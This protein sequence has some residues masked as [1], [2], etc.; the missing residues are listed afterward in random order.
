MNVFSTKTAALRAAPD[1]AK[2]VRFTYGMVLNAEDFGQEF[3]YLSARDQWMVRDLVGYGTVSGLKVTYEQ[4]GTRPRLVV[5]PGVAV[6]PRGEMVRVGRAQCAYLNDW[7]KTDEAAARA[8]AAKASPTMS[9]IDAYVT[10]CY[11]ACETDDLPIPGEPCRDES[12]MMAPS[13]VA[14]DFKLELRLDPP[15]QPDEQAV[16]DFVTW[17]AGIPIVDG[18][19]SVT[20]SQFLEAIK[21]AATLI[22]S[23]PSSPP[24]FMYGAPPAAVQ[25]GRADACRY[26]RAAYRLWV[27]ELRARWSAS[28]WDAQAACCGATAPAESPESC[29]L[30]TRVSIPLVIGGP[31]G[32]QAWQVAAAPEP[33]IDDEERPFLVP[34]R[35]LQEWLWCGCACSSSGSGAAAEA[36]GLVVAAGHLTVTSPPQPPV[37]RYQLQA[38]RP[39]PLPPAPPAWSAGDFWVLF[40]DYQRPAPGGDFSYVVSVTPMVGP[41]VNPRL[42]VAAFDTEGIRLRLKNNTVPASPTNLEFMIE[43][44][45]YAR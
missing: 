6:T 22:G 1:P 17:L 21:Y 13:R 23:P 3:A 34:V 30:L 42:E 31:A 20:L 25:I 24:D 5:A 9:R 15:A 2:H 4:N 37:G 33:E 44:K 35:M 41:L 26:L 32:A 19:S 36:D 7:L 43:V 38:V 27:I 11:R 39:S 40:K 45:K 29:V 12:D 14:D 8:E 10:L 16:R 28:W 18:P